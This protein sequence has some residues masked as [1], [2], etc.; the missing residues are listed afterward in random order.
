MNQVDIFNGDKIFGY[1]LV[2]EQVLGML[3]DID[4]HK[5]ISHVNSILIEK[6]KKLIETISNGALIQNGADL[7]S[8]SSTDNLFMY[9]Y[10][11]SA[12]QL[13]NDASADQDIN[14]YLDNLSTTISD[15][16]NGKFEATKKLENF[17]ETIACL[18]DKDLD[19]MKYMNANEPFSLAI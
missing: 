14:G 16:E 13:I 7:N 17:F 11:S 5:S 1:S 3:Y 12:I 6:A 10:G 19:N 2:S 18:L 8:L 15:I 4:E 9:D